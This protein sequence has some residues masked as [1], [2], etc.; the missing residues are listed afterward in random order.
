MDQS[1]V[2]KAPRKKNTEYWPNSTEY[3]PLSEGSNSDTTI[4]VIS[5]ETRDSLEVNYGT[6]LP[7]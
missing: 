7:I 3:R 4:S 1:A 5:T 2:H 6:Q